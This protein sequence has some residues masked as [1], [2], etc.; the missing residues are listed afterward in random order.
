[1][2]SVRGV[3]KERVGATGVSFGCIFLVNLPRSR[4]RWRDTLL[5]YR[6]RVR[7]GPDGFDFVGALLSMAGVG[8][9]GHA[10]IEAPT[11]GRWP[12]SACSASSFCRTQCFQ[13]I[14]CQKGVP[15]PQGEIKPGWARA[16]V[17]CRLFQLLI[18]SSSNSQVSVSGPNASPRS[19]ASSRARCSGPSARW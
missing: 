4:W 6:I 5:C 18:W 7:V 16:F 19:I 11:D 12:S 15:R 2:I 17:G 1:M 14:P 13:V 8:L 3:F 10:V 9:P